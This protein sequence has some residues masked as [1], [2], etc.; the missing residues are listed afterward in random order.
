MKIVV[1][2]SCLPVKNNKQEK[3]DALVKFCQGVQ[4]V[5]DTGILHSGYTLVDADVA[6]ILGW[7][8]EGSK[9]TPHLKLRQDIINQQRLLNKKVLCIDS[10]LFLYKDKKNPKHYLRYSF[11]GVFPNTGEYCDQFPDSQKWSRISADL[12]CQLQNY[13]TSGSHVLLCLQRQGG[14]SMGGKNILDWA[15]KTINKIRTHSN[16]PIVLRPHPGDKTIIDYK[17]F[18]ANFPNVKLSDDTRSL[19]NDLEDCWA[20]VN[21]NSSPTVGAAIEG[22]PI[23]VTDPEHSQCKDIA[24]TD[25]SLIET[26]ARPDRQAWVERL[27][28]SHWNFTDLESGACWS[29]MRQFVGQQSLANVEPS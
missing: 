11:D 26:P 9:R 16:R 10:S 5:G 29:H 28:M 23:F 13:K 7:V 18:V 22:Y 19:M 20:V 8:H 1:Y 12:N 27:A 15:T 6:V 14:W 25:L 4:L 2:T 17:K 21:H 3:I 24:N